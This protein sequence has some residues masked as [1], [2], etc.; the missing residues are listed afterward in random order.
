MSDQLSA[1]HRRKDKTIGFTES[2]RQGR[3]AS[4]GQKGDGTFSYTLNGS[5]P[6]GEEDTLSACRILVNK[7]N[8]A[9][10]N[11]NQPTISEGIVDCQAVDSQRDDRKLYIQVV[12]ANVDPELWKTLNREGKIER[13]GNSTA[14][15][16]QIKS[17]ID[18]KAQKIAAANRPG[19]VLALDATRLPVLGFD[20]VFEAFCSKWSPWASTLGFNSVWLVGPDESLTWQLDTRS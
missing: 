9:G 2:A 14:L 19:L 8:N 17:A 7:L 3:S 5:S 18:T 11:W 20:A 10:G 12:R 15:A 13:K 6:Q 4:A 1:L 16:E